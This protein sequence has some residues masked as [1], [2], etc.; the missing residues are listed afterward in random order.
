VVVAQ[1]KVIFRHFSGGMEDKYE[2]PVMRA[3]HLVESGIRTPAYA[4]VLLFLAATYGLKINNVS[5]CFRS[6][7][8]TCILQRGELFECSILVLIL[9]LTFYSG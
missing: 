4:V 6:Y 5:Q 3:D 7:R 2:K 9:P 8:N 1:F